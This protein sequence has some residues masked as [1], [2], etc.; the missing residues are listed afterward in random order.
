MG[1]KYCAKNGLPKSNPVMGVKRFKSSLAE[2]REPR[3]YTL[4]EVTL[5]Y[6]TGSG[7]LK[8]DALHTFREVPA[9][10]TAAASAVQEF[11]LLTYRLETSFPSLSIVISFAPAGTAVVVTLPLGHR[12]QMF[13]GCSGVA[14]T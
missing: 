12:I 10:A 3:P 11:I 1:S 4:E 7:S 6:D 13:S 5:I 8:L 14:S 2:K 9:V